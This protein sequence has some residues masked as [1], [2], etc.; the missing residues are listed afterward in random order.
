MSV[1]R[2]ML[3]SYFDTTC[4]AVDEA[5]EIMQ[6]G[7]SKGLLR[8]SIKYV[9]AANSTLESVID[10]EMCEERDD[11]RGMFSG[12]VFVKREERLEVVDGKAVFVPVKKGDDGYDD[13]L[14]QMQQDVRSSTGR[15]P[16]V[17]QRESP[18]SLSLRYETM[19]HTFSNQLYTAL[20]CG[21][22]AISER[23][24]GTTIRKPRERA[25]KRLREAGHHDAAD[26]VG[27][28]FGNNALATLL[29][30]RNKVV[31]GRPGFKIL[32]RDDK[33]YIQ[34][35][36]TERQHT[37]FLYSSYTAASDAL[38][39]MARACAR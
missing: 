1:T 38:V 22:L 14:R 39:T 26:G 23:Y 33:L 25:L 27:Y 6:C 4:D 35:G 18:H 9:W 21:L 34:S 31:H 24:P 13:L 12:A 36:K 29:D 5:L 11:R 19:F 2:K 28:A 32:L 16:Y 8:R 10:W 17:V 3:D 30:M 15:N 37:P 7:K 20:E